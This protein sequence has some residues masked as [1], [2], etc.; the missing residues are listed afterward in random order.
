MTAVIEN[1]RQTI[2]VAE[3]AQALGIGR[4]AGYD[5][6]RR[7]EIPVIKIG[8]RLLVPKAALDRILKGEAA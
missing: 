6:V 2:T 3:A 4:N 7:G 8:K 5:A 1:A